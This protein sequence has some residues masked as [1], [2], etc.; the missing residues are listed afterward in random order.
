MHTGDAYDKW[1]NTY[2]RVENKTR[3]LEGIAIRQVLLGS[4]YHHILEIGCGTGK[5]TGWLAGL[6]RQMTALDFSEGMLEQA[7]QKVNDDRVTFRWADITQPWKVDPADL[8]C[9][10]LVLEHIEDLDFIFSQAA[11]T[12]VAGGR[13]YISELHPYRQMQGARARF[14]HEGKTHHLEY[15]VHH[16]SDYFNSALEHGFVCAG[17]NEWFDD[18]RRREVPRLVSYLF[19]L[20]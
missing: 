9:C 5:N 8:I 1:S 18:T 13:F 20:P 6:C 19:Q 4:S 7:K 11:A 14:E 10:S 17:L 3:D 16:I 2:D 12:L 15:F